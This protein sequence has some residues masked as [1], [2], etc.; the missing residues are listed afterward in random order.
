MNGEVAV[1]CAEGVP[2]PAQDRL[3]QAALRAGKAV[4]V[5]PV[6]D[7]IKVVEQGLVIE[8]LDREQL[9]WPVAWAYRPEL[10]PQ[11]DPP[12]ADWFVGAEM[13]NG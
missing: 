10:A 3:R 4:L 13:V 7:T 9:R 11:A 6:F 2:E 12:T 1:F 8:T 5:K